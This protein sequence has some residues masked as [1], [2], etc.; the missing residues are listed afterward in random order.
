VH[1]SES[2]RVERRRVAR[3]L[4]QHHRGVATVVRRHLERRRAGRRT[5]DGD[6]PRRATSRRPGV[7][8]FDV[9]RVD[10]AIAGA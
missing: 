6:G 1:A 5:R 7:E 4:V 2:T 10:G 3:R 9:Q 8:P